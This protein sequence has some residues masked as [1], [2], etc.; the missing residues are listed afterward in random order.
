[1]VN[2][3]FLFSKQNIKITCRNMFVQKKVSVFISNTFILYRFI[4]HNNLSLGLPVWT[5]C[6]STSLAVLFNLYYLCQNRFPLCLGGICLSPVILILSALTK[7]FGSLSFLFTLNIF[8]CCVNCSCMVWF[9]F[10][11]TWTLICNISSVSIQIE[12]G[13]GTALYFLMY[14][15]F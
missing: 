13:G 10:N 9:E 8:A 12:T 2:V 1:M 4:R 3:V 11:L 6:L 14:G 15:L 5:L 7:W